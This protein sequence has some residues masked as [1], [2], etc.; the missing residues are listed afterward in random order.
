[1]QLGIKCTSQ[2]KL[3]MKDLVGISLHKSYDF[4]VVVAGGHENITYIKKDC[5]NY[6][7]QLK[8]SFHGEET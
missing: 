8:R 4:V 7:E 1:M 3:E 5:R 2:K 6:I